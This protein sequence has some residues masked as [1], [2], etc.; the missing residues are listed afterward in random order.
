[1]SPDARN[2]IPP[3]RLGWSDAALE[4]LRR[5]I[6][7]CLSIEDT[8]ESDRDAT[9]ALAGLAWAGIKPHSLWD[10]LVLAECLAEV[11][12]PR[13]ARAV[14]ATFVDAD[15]AARSLVEAIYQV[16]AAAYLVT[17]TARWLAARRSFG[18]PVADHQSIRFQLAELT[19]MID[20]ARQ[21]GYAAARDHHLTGAARWQAG[22]ALRR[23]AQECLRLHGA[24]GQL[25]DHPVQLF[26]VDSQRISVEE[27][28]FG[29]IH[30][31]AW[32]PLWDYRRRVN[33]VVDSHPDVFGPSAWDRV[34]A[35]P[36][37]RRAVELLAGAGLL[38]PR[39][40]L[41]Q[42]MAL[43]EELAMLPAG[44]V[45][46]SQLDVATRLLA[47]FDSTVDVVE[48]AALG[49]TLVALAA[50]EPAGGV[51]LDSMT[52][53]V[54]PEG[55]IL[56]LDGEKWFSSNAPFADQVL[57]LARDTRFPDAAPGRHTLVLVPVTTPGTQ[58]SPLRTLGH[59]GITGRVVLAGVRVGADAVVG[60]PGSG[61]LTLMRHWTHERVMLA[62]RMTAMAG[63]LLRVAGGATPAWLHAEVAQE[64]AA[65]RH[66]LDLLRLG[67]CPPE[68][69]AAAKLRSA[70]LLRTVAEFVLRSAPDPATSA[71][72]G[73]ILRDAAGLTLAGGSEEALLML[74]G[75][76][77]R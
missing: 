44:A 71:P 15:D 64:R 56:V 26:Y 35:V 25:E 43:H 11:L 9:W 13:P 77:I 63:G 14:L 21:L 60:P 22:R 24:S 68:V 46:L 39:S 20:G 70:R 41:E 62:V 66:G 30:A 58:V 45:V 65:Y 23:T 72:A 75:R 48:S 16:A 52:T 8:A 31:D 67:A 74:M 76:A 40:S 34:D 57:V 3:H 37:G 4:N 10:N 1:M 69:A 28:R 19:A 36:P 55:G 6:A 59:R 33:A 27:G 42:S 47:R 61:L 2:R 54:R 53:T 18:R 49:R 51:D 73:R 38:D 32:D 50:T 7:G 5:T 17:R 12:T 29:E